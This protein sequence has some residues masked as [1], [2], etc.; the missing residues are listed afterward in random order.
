MKTF[1]MLWRFVIVWYF[2]QLSLFAASGGLVPIHLRCE[3]MEN[4]LG[5]DVLK[6]RLNWQLKAFN[7]TQRGQKQFAYQVLVASNL[8][9][10]KLNQGDF[11]DS[12]QKASDQTLHIEYAGKP[13]SESGS[14]FLEGPGLGPGKKA[15]SWSE[16]AFWSMGLLDRKDWGAKW[17][18][19]PA[20]AVSPEVEAKA[21]GM[22]NYGYHSLSV[23][24]AETEKWVVLDLGREQPIDS[25]KLFP[26]LMLDDSPK[27]NAHF[28]PRRFKVEVADKSDFTD[29]RT[30]VD[31]ST[32]DV[33]EPHAEPQ[34]YKLGPATARYFRLS[35][36]RA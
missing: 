2:C 4:P 25:V 16:P 3:Y 1:I 7:S 13:L 5:V 29:A 28:F 11:W 15:S 31:Y 21:T 27:A 36:N 17:I 10:L 30:V 23:K 22:L 8:E 24:S 35:C 26:V 12:G 20:V 18:A 34:L 32:A 19:D 9:N 14:L 33:P 6:P